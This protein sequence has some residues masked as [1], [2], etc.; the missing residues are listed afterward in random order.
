[1]DS[2]DDAADYDAMDHRE[3]NRVFVDD[4]LAAADSS[5]F[6]VQSSKLGAADST[7]NIEPETLNLDVLDL[8]TGTAQ[9]PVELCRRYANCRVMAVDAA[10]SMLDLAR[11]NVEAASLTERIELAHV[12]AKSLPFK[13]GM[14]DVV[15]S[16]SIVHHI[17]QPRDV[18]REA[19]RVTKTGG[20]LFVRDLLRP[21]SEQ[22]LDN[23]VATYAAGCNDHQRKL[24]ADSLHAALSL[25][26]I[27]EL[28][29]SLGF[30]RATV[31]ATSDRH[32]TWSAA[33]P[34]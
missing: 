11:Y 20:L 29:A 12:D 7:L 34:H 25:D 5:R 4:L 14:F 9:I 22:Q 6:K 24:F 32:W 30:D 31:Q 10:V 18:L 13:E 27:R 19:V 17:P 33:N 28:V 23:L 16:N 3:V 21:D 26:E 15:M 2:L 8:G 1:M